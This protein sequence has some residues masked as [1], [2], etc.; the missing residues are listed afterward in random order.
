MAKNLIKTL[1][2]D[3]VSFLKFAILFYFL[4][5]LLLFLYQKTKN[6]NSTS[7]NKIVKKILDF[8]A[9]NGGILI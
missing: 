9:N 8:K 4:F 1:L 6:V 2:F 7:Q 3:I 5:I